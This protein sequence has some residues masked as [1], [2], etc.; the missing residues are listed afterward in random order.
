MNADA[1]T[2]NPAAP[3]GRFLPDYDQYPDPLGIAGLTISHFDVGDVLGAGALHRVAR[4]VAADDDRRDEQP[5]LVDLAGVEER[6][7]QARA[8]LQQQRLHAAI[9]ELLERVADPLC[10]GRT[11]DADHLD[12]GRLERLGGCA[13]RGAR[14]DDDRRHVAGG[15]HERRVERQPRGRV[16]HDAVG[17]AVDVRTG[18]ATTVDLTKSK[19]RLTNSPGSCSVP[20]NWMPYSLIC[21]EAGYNRVPRSNR[22]PSLN[23]EMRSNS[24]TSIPMNGSSAEL[25]KS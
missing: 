21:P 11:L 20:T 25:A 5:Q 2:T 16:E 9:A 6:A 3:T 22:L 12:A 14:D 17:L 7:G 4:L 18:D 10:V 8:A 24:D 1:E 13:V 23:I 15:L 19:K